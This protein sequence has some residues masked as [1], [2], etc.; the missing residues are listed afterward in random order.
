MVSEQPRV[1]DLV[2]ARFNPQSVGIFV[3]AGQAD[4][5]LHAPFDTVGEALQHARQMAAT[6]S[7]DVW[8]RTAATRFELIASYR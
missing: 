2:V 7:V 8:H 1:G 4:H 6:S 3:V 5:R